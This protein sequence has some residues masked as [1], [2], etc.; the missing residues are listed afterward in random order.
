MA[1]TVQLASKFT[2]RIG[3]NAYLAKFFARHEESHKFDAQVSRLL[4]HATM[5]ASYAARDLYVLTHISTRDRFP[6]YANL[7]T[8]RFMQYVLCE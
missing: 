2:A 3:Q 1:G 7:L 5:L 6:A 4:V 8:S